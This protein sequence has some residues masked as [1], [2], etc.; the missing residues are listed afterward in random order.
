MNQVGDTGTLSIFPLPSTGSAVY[1]YVWNFWDGTSTATEQ[2][3]VIKVINIGGQP[4]SPDAL[5]YSVRPVAI[6]GQS[7]VLYGSIPANNPPTIL[8]G[9]ISTNDGFFSYNTQLSV[10]AI[11]QDGDAFQ[12]L[13]YSGTDPIGGGATTAVGN[14]SG[15]WV[16]NGQTIIANYPAKQNVF[17]M[18]VSSDRN[19]TCKVIDVRGGTSSIDFSLRGEP[20]PPPVAAITAG[21]PGVSSDSTTPPIARIGPGQTVD[22]TVYTAPMP[23]HNISFSWNF[24][25]SLGWTMPPAATAGTVT[26]LPNGGYQNTVHRD[27]SAEVV[28]SGTSKGVVAEV[29][30]IAVNKISGQTTHSDVDYEVTLI[31]NTDPSSVTISRV[32]NN[33]YVSGVGPVAAGVKIE[34]SGTGA[35]DNNDVLFYKW[36]FAQP[37]A[38]S[39]VHFWGPKV[40]YDTTGYVSNQTVQGQLHVYDNMGGTL[41]TLLPTTNIL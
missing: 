23:T 36:S 25:G 6:D 28:S 20:N 18:V 34:F 39:T 26:V 37:F 5:L 32:V 27:I 35:D 29:R 14:L 4:G 21:I 22:F 13:W 24:N 8:Y 11:D 3:F 12:F 33:A 1:S 17:S 41:S 15:T 10:T 38:P 2:P 30:V 9:S 31:K 19:V 40:L 7:T 16:G